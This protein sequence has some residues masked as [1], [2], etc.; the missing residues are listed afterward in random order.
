MTSRPSAIV[1]LMIGELD[2]M[3]SLNRISTHIVERAVAEWRRTPGSALI[4]ESAPM[5]AEAVRLGVAESD[6]T[7]AL[8][9]PLGH[10]TRLVALWYARSPYGRGPARLVTHAMHARRAVRIFEKT[11]T[12][13]TAIGL[14]LAFDRE[15]PDWKLRGAGVFR[16]YNM[17]AHV[18]CVC[19]G[20]L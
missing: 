7:T 12:E 18:Y 8:T 1:A 6:V 3:S 17:A 19:R 20:W 9:Q 4:C 15:D 10:T 2:Y 14:D 11:G 5:A 13:A 16:A